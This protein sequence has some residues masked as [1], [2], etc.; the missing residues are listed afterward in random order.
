MRIAAFNLG[1][2][3]I[4]LEFHSKMNTLGG[5]II[6]GINKAVDLCEKDHKALVISN[7]GEN[8]SAGANLGL[9]FMLAI[10]QELEELDL[11]VRT[12]QKSMLKLKY[13]PFPVIV[14]PHGLCLGGACELS[15]H[16]DKI[17]AHAETYMGLVELG[18]C[19][20]CRWWQ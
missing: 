17:I 12:F 6:Q 3:V 15:M 19:D 14:A 16:S 13:A 10:E 9:V 4:N 2:G 5:E 20:S 7:Q 8:F 1:D 11:V 18:R